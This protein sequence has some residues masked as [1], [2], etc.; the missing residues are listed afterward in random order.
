M[1]I[2]RLLD[3][4]RVVLQD[5]FHIRV[6]GDSLESVKSRGRVAPFFL[7]ARVRITRV[8]L[9]AVANGARMPR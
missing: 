9:A 6:G 2:P 8:T 3:A 4:G 5:V 1:A 7:N